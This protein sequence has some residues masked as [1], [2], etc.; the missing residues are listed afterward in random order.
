MDTEGNI[1]ADEASR[2]REQLSLPKLTR[3]RAVN[4]DSETRET[5]L[6]LK[7]SFI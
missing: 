4:G 5:T 3:E 2:S 7:P 1:A 6:L